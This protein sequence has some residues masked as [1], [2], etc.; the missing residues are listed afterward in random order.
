[1][2]MKVYQGCQI[3]IEVSKAT[4]NTDK[5]TQKFFQVFRYNP[6]HEQSEQHIYS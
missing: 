6:K 5:Y 2:R 1:M 4:G 3:R